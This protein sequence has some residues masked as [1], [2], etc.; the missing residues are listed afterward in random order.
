MFKYLSNVYFNVY[1][2]Y[3]TQ[4]YQILKKNFFQ[5]LRISYRDFKEQVFW[6]IFSIKLDSR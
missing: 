5:V 4:D 6:L 3:Y 1:V 2:F